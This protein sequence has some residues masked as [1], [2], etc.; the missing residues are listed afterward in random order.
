MESRIAFTQTTKRFN[1]PV[2]R[3]FISL[4]DMNSLSLMSH[5]EL[6]ENIWKSEF[7]GL[8][9]HHLKQALED[10]NFALNRL[11]SNRAALRG[12]QNGSRLHVSIHYR[13]KRRL[14]RLRD[15]IIKVTASASSI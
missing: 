6:I 3:E 10:E 12:L 9:L 4:Y 2:K 1:C 13:T 11:G 14:H 8:F 5:E 15:F 7:D